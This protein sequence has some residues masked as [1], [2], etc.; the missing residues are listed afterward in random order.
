MMKCVRFRCSISEV[1][2]TS[3]FVF[4]ARAFHFSDWLDVALKLVH[5]NRL[6]MVFY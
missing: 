5:N 4:R 2:M 6:K 1:M 3:F